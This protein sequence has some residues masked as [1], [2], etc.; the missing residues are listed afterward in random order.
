MVLVDRREQ[1]EPDDRKREIRELIPHTGHCDGEADR[2]PLAKPHERSIE[3]DPAIPT[4]APA[5]E[6]IASAVEA[7]LITNA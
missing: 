2:T 4:A 1:S 6:T 3:Y 7:W 5:G